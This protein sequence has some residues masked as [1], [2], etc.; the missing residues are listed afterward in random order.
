[1]GNSHLPEAI[2]VK[3]LGILMKCLIL[4]ILASLVK[5]KT[6]LDTQARDLKETKLHRKQ[7]E[8]QC[9]MLEKEVVTWKDKF[10][11]EH[12]RNKTNQ[13]DIQV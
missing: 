3:S 1:M 7:L 5:L 13:N 2:L 10:E 11:N 8:K 9:S 12:T 4:P 6:T